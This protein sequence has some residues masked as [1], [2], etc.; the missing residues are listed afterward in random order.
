MITREQFVQAA[1]LLGIVGAAEDAD[2]VEELPLPAALVE[3][4]TAH[5]DEAEA[6]QDEIG[7]EI[8]RVLETQREIAQ[9]I[10]DGAVR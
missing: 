3:F 9:A 7:E 10:L 1:A 4:A 8:D 2:G 6:L 5:A